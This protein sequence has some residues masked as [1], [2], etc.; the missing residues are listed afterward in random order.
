MPNPGHR[1]PT[2]LDVEGA[3]ST[4][5]SATGLGLSAMLE[6]GHLDCI[7]AYSIGG[8]IRRPDRDERNNCAR[9]GA[10]VVRKWRC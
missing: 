7:R 8:R 6:V 4:P 2:Q 10:A 1:S 9:L 5:R 3:E